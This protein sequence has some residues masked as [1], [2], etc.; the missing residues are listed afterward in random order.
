MVAVGGWLVYTADRHR[1]DEQRSTPANHTTH[2]H[3]HP[4]A[5]AQRDSAAQGFAAHAGIGCGGRTGDQVGLVP[6]MGGMGSMYMA[7]K[8]VR[9]GITPSQ[10]DP[11]WPPKVHLFLLLKS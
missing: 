3:P 8:R 10:I 4:R 9:G 5:Q 2:L 6:K 11:K 1:A 7:A